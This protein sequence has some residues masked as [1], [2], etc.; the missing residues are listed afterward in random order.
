MFDPIW[1]L[2]LG[3]FTGIL[4][5]GLLQKGRVAK[6]Q[7]I[8]GQF[9]LRDWTVVKIMGT[10]VVVGAVGIY[11]LLPTD[12]VSLHLKPLAWGGIIFGGL[13]FG[14]GMAVLGYCPGTG[15]AACGEGR[16]DA[17]AGSSGC[18]SGRASMSPFIRL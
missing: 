7:V 8:L 12:A 11:A 15:V 10:A 16:K 9:L 1:K 13:C 18:C 17:V 2:A 5:G 14:I 6:Y 4:F 3:L